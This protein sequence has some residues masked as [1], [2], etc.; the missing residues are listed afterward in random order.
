MLNNNRYTI[1]MNKTYYFKNR[2]RPTHYNLSKHL[3]RRGYCFQFPGDINDSHLEF[4]AELCRWLEYKHLLSQLTQR[5]CPEVMPKTWTINDQNH[6]AVLKGLQTQRFFEKGNLL[7]LKP[8]LLNNGEG[9]RL[10]KSCER[11][12]QHYSGAHRYGGD[13][14]LQQYVLH[15]H[16][17]QGHKYTIRM[18]VVITNCMGSYIYPHGYFN[19][20]RSRY[21]SQKFDR[22]D[23]HLTNE[24]LHVNGTGQHWQIPTDR[25][26]CFDQVY[27]GL[28]QIAVKITQGL[29][30]LHPRVFSQGCH[31]PAMGLFGFDYIIDASLRPWL[32]EVNHF[33]CFPVDDNHLLQVPLYNSFWDKLVDSILEPMVKFGFASDVSTFFDPLSLP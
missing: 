3:Q 4:H 15:P 30:L 23:C 25:H 16:L 31:S 10:I 20:A 22:L 32:L 6:Q 13:H 18:F 9:I 19:V 2:D 11:L 1:S 21:E 5:Y 29:S 24:H 8:S 26:P 28:R 7:I 14:V 17:L 33:P 27:L 12:R